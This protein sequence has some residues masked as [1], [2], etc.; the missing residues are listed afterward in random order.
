MSGLPAVG[1]DGVGDEPEAFEDRVCGEFPAFAVD[2]DEVFGALVR[3]VLAP[4]FFLDPDGDVVDELFRGPVGDA[5][6]VGQGS[7]DLAVGARTR[8]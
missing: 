2:G 5:C 4:A 6:H 1:A 7:A 8:L 3:G